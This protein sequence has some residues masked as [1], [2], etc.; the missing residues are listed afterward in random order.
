MG[1]GGGSVTALQPPPQAENPEKGEYSHAEGDGLGFLPFSPLPGPEAAQ[2]ADP[3]PARAGL[4]EVRGYRRLAPPKPPRAPRRKPGTLPG[5]AAVSPAGHSLPGVPLEWCDG[6][7]RLANM[8]APD[9][10]IPARWAVLAATSARLLRDNGAELHGA[11]WDALDVFGLHATAPTTNPSG[12]G[13][14]WLLTEYGEVLDVA[15]DA[16]GM[17]RAPDGARMALYKKQAP[18][19]AGILPAWNLSGVSA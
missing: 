11:G 2:N 19:R 7:A 1:G 13:L 3:H 16:V 8:T 5:S 9:A 17:R 14:A 12:W 18:A 10:I 6:V 4:A 15:Q